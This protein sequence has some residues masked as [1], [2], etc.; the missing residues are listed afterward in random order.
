MMI[1]D[2]K[3]TVGGE[4]YRRF[5]Q[6]RVRQLKGQVKVFQGDGPIEYFESRHGKRE[7]L[8]FLPGFAD[9]KENFYTCAQFFS[10][11]YDIVVPDLPGFGQ[12]FRHHEQLYNL[13]N[14]KRWLTDFINHIGWDDFHLVGNS[15][16][17]AVAIEIALEMP[18][19]IKSLTLADPGGVVFNDRNSIYQEFV[20]GRVLFRIN[21]PQ[22]FEYFLDRVFS[23]R[24]IIPP[25]VKDY[26][27]KEFSSHGEWNCKML[28]D[29]IEGIIDLNDPRMKEVVLNERIKELSVPTLVIWGEVDSFF[30]VSTASFMQR[31]IPNC[32][33]HIIEGCGH[34]PQVE[35]PYTFAR[36]VKKFIAKTEA[37]ILN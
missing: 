3:L 16:G 6:M 34:G 13:K 29:M 12:S 37:E 26:L 21:T 20:N 23:K 15:L 27:Y 24:P 8:L 11:E 19:R 7:R 36:V 32:E 31:E 9:Y 35:A 10:R 14:Y 30:P 4:I 2:W 5:Q 22:R 18:E 17:G 25:F 33:M 1:S 28:S